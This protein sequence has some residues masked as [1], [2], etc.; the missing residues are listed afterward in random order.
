MTKE[1]CKSFSVQAAQ[2][3]EGAFDAMANSDAFPNV[4][5]VEHSKDFSKVTITLGT[6]AELKMADMYD[7]IADRSARLRPTSRSRARTSSAPSRWSARTA[8]CWTRPSS[9]TT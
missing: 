7:A 3:R 2:E 9:R 5:K 8:R 1:R 6:D 4:T